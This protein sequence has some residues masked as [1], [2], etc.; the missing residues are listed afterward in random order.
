[1]ANKHLIS[2]RRLLIK[3]LSLGQGP[4]KGQTDKQTAPNNI[5][6]PQPLELGGGKDLIIVY[7]LL[8]LLTAYRPIHVYF[9]RASEFICEYRARYSSYI[10]ASIA[11]IKVVRRGLTIKR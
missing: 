7:P 3:A 1:M 6:P 4:D 8:D 11:L 2:R 9:C 10:H 5:M